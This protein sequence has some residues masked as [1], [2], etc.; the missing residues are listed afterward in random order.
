MN[1]D[2]LTPGQAEF[3]QVLESLT[4]SEELRKDIET[5]KEELRRETKP[6]VN[7]GL[8]RVAGFQRNEENR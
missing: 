4:I 3:F 6:V 5:T 8:N 1:N 7:R 2:G